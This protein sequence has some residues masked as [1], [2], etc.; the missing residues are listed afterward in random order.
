ML[1]RHLWLVLIAAGCSV[2]N[3][4][5]LRTL[6]QPV[7]SSKLDPLLA[8]ARAAYQHNFP[9]KQLVTVYNTQR[10]WT[11]HRHPVSG[12]VV[13]RTAETMF[14][15]KKG[16]TCTWELMWLVEPNAGGTEWGA[17]DV[18]NPQGEN[19]PLYLDRP[20]DCASLASSAPGAGT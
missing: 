20:A 2:L 18:T 16:A 14:A 10:D 15:Y 5:T 8:D 13:Q 4:P 11:I 17:L 12:V 7:A 6:P 3:Q 1:T 9:D 19:G